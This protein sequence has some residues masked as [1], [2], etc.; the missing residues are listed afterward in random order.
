MFRRDALHRN[1]G[2]GSYQQLLVE[3]ARH[4]PGA[5]LMTTSEHFIPGRDVSVEATIAL[6]QSR[7]AALNFNVEESAWLNP[8]EG[9]WSVHLRDVD[10]PLLGVCGR[11]VTQLAARASA[12]GEF[13][14]RLACN[15]FWS[16]Y[17]LG[18]MYAGAPF[19]HFPQEKWFSLS[20]DW[21][22][23]AG[24]LTP[25][26]QDFYDPGGEIDPETLVDLNTG[27]LARGI[28]ALPFVRQRDGEAVYF[29]VNI[30]SNL[31]GS[32]GMGAGATPAEARTHALSEVVE[33][34][35]KFRVIREG[36]CLPAVPQAAIDRYP[37]IAGGI[38]RLREAGFGVLVRDASF[39]GIFPV[40]N[41]TLLNPRD[42][43]C[44]VS[45]GAHLCFEV[46]LERALTGLLQ[47]RGLSS[48]EGFAP[49]GMDLEEVA[50]SPNLNAHLV[51]SGGVVHWNFLRN[52]SEHAFCDWNFDSITERA[53]AHLC[54]IVQEEG[55]D[56]YIADYAHLGV[57]ACRILVPGMSE[58]QPID[59]LEF[60]NNSIGNDLRPS[61]L[62]LHA[63][64]DEECEELLEALNDL[65]VDDQRLVAELIGLV[66]EPGTMW[67]DLRVGELKAM[68][69]LTI[70]DEQGI[71]S[72]LTWVRFCQQLNP[73]RRS[74]YHCIESL[75]A[76]EDDDPYQEALVGLY[77]QN[78]LDQAVRHLT[79]EE[80]FFGLTEKSPGLLLEG[81]ALHA[82]LLAAYA[83]VQGSKLQG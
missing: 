78:V 29:P 71:E 33:H 55:N 48:L 35:V 50:S 74:V 41:I 70:G 5:D 67:E 56:I 12:L 2:Q 22:W 57:Y 38:Q 62:Q 43:G 81:C 32:N 46:A 3:W 18:E 75:L 52:D 37:H 61:I 83:K 21:E 20:G 53:F 14:E 23:P 82:S 64:S 13:L 59:G 30:I 47:G 76:L 34:F 39:G 72:G 44:L 68:L 42:H 10:C 26:L 15:E 7:L 79:G 54:S 4:F 25:E 45:F 31:Y 9:V 28:C 19:S 63:L 16:G 40:L 77:G 69:A 36:L 73:Y 49:P 65:G 1:A 51:D 58:I 80:R 11:G 27:N 24:L 60:E 8:V 17:Y 66:P 6:L